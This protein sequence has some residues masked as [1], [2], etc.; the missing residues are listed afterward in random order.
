MLR[1]SNQITDLPVLSLRTGGEIAKAGEPIINPNNLKIEGW[2]CTDKF[3]KEQL[4][5]LPQ[6]VRDFVPQGIAVNDHDVLTNPEEL[7][8]LQKILE[9]EFELLGKQVITNHKRRLGKVADYAVD[10]DSLV[11]QKLYVARPMYRSLSEGQLTID[12]SQI[13][14]INNRRILVRDADVKAR[15]GAINTAP[16]AG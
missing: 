5:L 6:D 8:R 7:I 12:R 15:A 1:L 13:I 9:L 2:F 16:A 3:S 4:V 11:I 10:A 14:E